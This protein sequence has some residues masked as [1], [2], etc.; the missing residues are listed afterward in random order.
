MSQ[1]KSKGNS[2]KLYSTVSDVNVSSQS[3]GA[4][5]DMIAS[6]F[7]KETSEQEVIYD[8][9]IVSEYSLSSRTFSEA[10]IENTSTESDD[11]SN[12]LNGTPS[13]TKNQTSED[14][15]ELDKEE[16]MRLD[17][18]IDVDVSDLLSSSQIDDSSNDA[19]NAVKE[20]KIRH[21]TIKISS[22]ILRE[23]YMW[24]RFFIQDEDGYTWVLHIYI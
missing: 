22:E 1:T 23:K 16:T 17:S 13:S 20:S 19:K 14:N 9:G 11:K 15:S 4:P 18:G 8:S 10:D 5:N 24:D 6:K 21:E 7:E 12:A 2:S 3:A